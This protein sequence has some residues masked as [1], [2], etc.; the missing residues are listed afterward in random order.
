LTD[1]IHEARAWLDLEYEAVFHPFADG[2]RWALPANPDLGP[3]IE[4]TSSSR[5]P[6]QFSPGP[7]FTASRSSVP[8]RLGKGQFYLMTI[9]DR[10]GAPLDG[11]MN[12]RRNVPANAPV[13]QY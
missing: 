12:Y 11:A 8:K 2:A 10:E 1:A 6:I 3:A 4:P 5:V 13:T 9:V 7:S